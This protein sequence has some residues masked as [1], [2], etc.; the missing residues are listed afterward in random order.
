MNVPREDLEAQAATRVPLLDPT[1]PA[2]RGAA[3]ESIRKYQELHPI[4][5][6]NPNG[7]FPHFVGKTLAVTSEVSLDRTEF[8]RG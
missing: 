5:F 1:D 4:W 6:V 2:Q 3:L 8:D 7:S